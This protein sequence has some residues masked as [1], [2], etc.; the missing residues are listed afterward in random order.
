MISVVIPYYSNSDGLAILLTLLQIQSNPPRLIIV[1]DN[2]KNKEGLRICKKYKYHIPIKTYT[3]IGTIYQSWNKG[4]ES[5]VDDILIINDDV[6]LPL[7][8]IEILNR[9]QKMYPALCYV[10]KTP[11]IEHRQKMAIDKKF[12]WLV[13]SDILCQKT[14]WMPGFCFFL[15]RTTINS[16]GLFDTKF[17]IWYGDFDYQERLHRYSLKTNQPSILRINSLYIYHFG[18]LSYNLLSQTNQKIIK[19]DK[20]ILNEKYHNPKFADL[21]LRKSVRVNRKFSLL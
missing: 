3:D 15:P 14:F 18:T 10:P 12:L 8:S 9:A 5:C 17:R 11:S 6:L 21:I 16:I 20:R 1:I 13:K 2:S 7:N 4:I 19:S